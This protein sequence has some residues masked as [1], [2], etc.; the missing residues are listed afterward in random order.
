MSEAPVVYHYS[1]VTGEYLGSSF[2]DADPLD[3][4][5]WVVPAFATL[6][7]PDDPEEGFAAVFGDGEWSTIE[8]HRG[9]T[10]WDEDGHPV[11]ID[12]LG[13]PADEG[14]SDVEPEPEPE[15]DPDPVQAEPVRVACALRVPIVDGEVLQ[16]GGAYR[17]MAMVLMDEGLF[18][19]IFSQDLGSEPY[20][21]PNN[22]VSVEISEWG[23][24]YA[25]LEVRDH[26]GG[27][28]ITPASFGFSLYQ[29]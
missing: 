7:V 4:G 29:I 20:V 17:V 3:A 27:S 24:D 18:L 26:A 22:G 15:P 11:V 21:I 14:L 23:G 5:R 8:D 2:A 13:D 1:P 10:W 19:A 12:F 9:E 28:L 16:I 6:L 25:M